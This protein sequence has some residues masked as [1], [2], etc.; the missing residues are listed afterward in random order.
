MNLSHPP[1]TQSLAPHWVPYFLAAP[2]F[3]PSSSRV[4][5]ILCKQA[6]RMGTSKPKTEASKQ[7]AQSPATRVIRQDE[8]PS[9]GDQAQYAVFDDDSMFNSADRQSAILRSAQTGRTGLPKKTT[10]LNQKSRKTA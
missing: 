5:V 6:K 3:L 8:L 10:A 7:Q 9:V 2:D 4:S 1:E